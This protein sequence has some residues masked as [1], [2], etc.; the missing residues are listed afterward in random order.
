[1]K[2]NEKQQ[3]DIINLFTD[4]IARTSLNYEERTQA[5]EC[6]AFEFKERVFEDNK[7]ETI[8]SVLKDIRDKL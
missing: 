2:L 6:A 1:M 7:E 5:I 3:N 4:I 8:L